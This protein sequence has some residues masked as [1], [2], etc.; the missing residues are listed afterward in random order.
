MISRRTGLVLLGSVLTLAGP[1][2]CS[3]GGS[4]SATTSTSGSGGSGTTVTTTHTTT[5]TGSSLVTT[6]GGGSNAGAML[7]AT[8]AADSDCGGAPLT[9]ILPSANNPVFGGGPAAGYCSET[10]TSDN[11]CP[12]SG[13]CLPVS[14][15]TSVCVLTCTLGPT[16]TSI[17]E[18]L[19]PDKCL[20]R[21]D[22]AC[23]AID[24]EGTAFGCIPT[25]GSNTQC[26]TG[27]VCAPGAALASG[28]P[29]SVCVP[30]ASAGVGTG[31]L[32]TVCDPNGTTDT[33]TGFCL[34]F[35]M[36]TDGGPNVAACS[37]ACVLGGDVMTGTSCGGDGTGL[38]AF[39]NEQTSG[40][41]DFGFCA[42]AC[43]AQTDCQLPFLFCTPITNLTGTGNG[44]TDN[45]WCFGATPCPN[46]A[47]DCASA[48]G[49]T[50]EPTAAGPFCISTKYPLPVADAGADSGDD[51]GADA[52]ETD[53]GADAGDAG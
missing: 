39:P 49:T 15:G 45:G 6:G 12:S 42:G 40:A 27:E 3:S 4:S 25:C 2:A 35:G 21:G 16:L 26:P 5:T 8:C 53:G 38:C 52:G 22:V 41:G 47:T 7:G 9:C 20:G 13:N 32:G 31:A 46:G 28:L 18:P 1:W 23:T 37:A 50:C 14:S 11:D 36:E 51:G 34:N 30:T 44:E 17:N 19:N 10:C 24:Q 43:K 29:T 48:A 33:C